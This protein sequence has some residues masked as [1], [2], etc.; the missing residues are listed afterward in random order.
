MGGLSMIENLHRGAGPGGLMRVGIR[1]NLQMPVVKTGV[2]G[3]AIHSLA[4]PNGSN[5]LLPGRRDI[6]L[7]P[8]YP[9]A[10][11]FSPPSTP[12]GLTRRGFFFVQPGSEEGPFRAVF[13]G[14]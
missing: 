2:A 5:L 4:G 14:K 8:P 13:S 7:S 11:A 3:D 12:T 9:T 6:H 10:R 1:G